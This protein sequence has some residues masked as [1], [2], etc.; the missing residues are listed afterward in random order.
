MYKFD[1]SVNDS[2]LFETQG[3]TTLI[4]T[5]PHEALVIYNRYYHPGNGVPGCTAEKAEVCSSAFAMRF[6][7]VRKSSDSND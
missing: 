1:S 2:M 5:A 3:Y 7:A 4:Q 6:R